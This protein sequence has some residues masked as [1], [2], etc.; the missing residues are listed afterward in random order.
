MAPVDGRLFLA[1]GKSG[2][3]ELTADG[4]R[5]LRDDLT[6]WSVAE[7]HGRVYFT[8]TP[9]DAAYAELDLATGQWRQLSY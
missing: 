2:V 3:A 8:I 9:G 4:V 7:G 6:P 1:A 5:I